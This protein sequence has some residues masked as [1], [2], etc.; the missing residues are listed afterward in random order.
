MSRPVVALASRDVP[1]GQVQLEPFGD[2]WFHVAIGR[3]KAT[4][5][6]NLSRAEAAQLRALL[7]ELLAE[8]ES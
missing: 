6:L 1:A 5:H 8:G 4:K 2:G 7:A 3:R